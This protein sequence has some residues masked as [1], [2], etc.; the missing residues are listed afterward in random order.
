[1]SKV[2]EVLAE[3]ASNAAMNNQTSLNDMLASANLTEAQDLAIKTNNMDS[4]REAVYDLPE[5]KCFPLLVPKDKDEEEENN[6]KQEIVA[7]F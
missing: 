2:M 1:M 6:L 4:L 3:M 5:I 7:N